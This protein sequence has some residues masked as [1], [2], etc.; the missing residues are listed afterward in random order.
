MLS[1]CMNFK[2][3]SSF[4]FLLNLPYKVMDNLVPTISNQ[5]FMYLSVNEINMCFVGLASAPQNPL[6]FWSFATLRWNSFHPEDNDLSHWGQ[7]LNIY[8]MI[9]LTYIYQTFCNIDYIGSEYFLFFF[10]WWG[11]ICLDFFERLLSSAITRECA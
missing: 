7:Y 8:K 4:Y 5:L 2:A 3:T 6:K 11:I 9:R 10:F 1:V